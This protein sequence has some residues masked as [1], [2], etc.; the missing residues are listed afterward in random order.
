MTKRDGAKTSKAFENETPLRPRTV[1]TMVAPN[2]G[3]SDTMKQTGQR[4]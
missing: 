2:K 3:Y 4:C 1:D